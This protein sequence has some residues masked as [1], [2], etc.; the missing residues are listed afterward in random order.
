MQIF[1]LLEFFFGLF[2][3]VGRF[4]VVYAAVYQKD[5]ENIHLGSLFFLWFEVNK[6]RKN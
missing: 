6:S 3:K 1:G 5:K 2:C 4:F